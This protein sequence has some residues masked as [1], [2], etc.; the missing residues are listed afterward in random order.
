MPLI[1]LSQDTAEDTEAVMVVDTTTQ[2]KG[3]EWAE[4]AE[5]S[6]EVATRGGK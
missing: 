3:H 6:V 2:T 5:A 1:F 4:V